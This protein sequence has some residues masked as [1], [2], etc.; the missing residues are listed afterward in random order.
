M[1]FQESRGLTADGIA[2]ARTLKACLEWA[3]GHRAE[4]ASILEKV[5]L[6]LQTHRFIRIV[7]DEG[8]SVVP[9][10]KRISVSISAENYKGGLDRIYVTDVLLAA[11]KTATLYPGITLY[12]KKSGKP[13]KLSKQQMKMLELLA[14][15]YKN[16]EIAKFSKLA[17]PTVKGHLMLAYE[18]LDV[19]NAIDAILKAKSLGL[20]K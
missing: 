20:I 16:H 5:L 13:V 17:I 14:Q 7:A 10:L 1:R 11:H 6:D 15:G 2:E 19:N 9:I 3:S 18:K 12:F 4:A 8:A